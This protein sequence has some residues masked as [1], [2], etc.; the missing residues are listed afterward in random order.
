MVSGV[1]QGFDLPSR[2]AICGA[3]AFS[4][5]PILWEELIQQWELSQ[6]EVDYINLQQGYACAVCKSS[7]R[8]MAL[9]MAITRTYNTRCTLHWLTRYTSFR[10]RRVLEIN[11]AGDLNRYLARSWRHRLACYPEYDM[12]KLSLPDSSFDLVVHSD[13]LEHIP[14]PLAALKECR[15]VLVPGGACCYTVP[16]VVGRLSRSRNGLPPSYHGQP[17]TTTGDYI[18]QTEVGADM[19]CLPLQAGFRECRIVTVGFPAAQALICLN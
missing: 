1:P 10:F 3:T 18:V 9:G 12:M 19:W 6:Y 17:S 4:Y 16:I 13:T 5:N 11:E 15:R 7:L 2:C 14:D 8:S